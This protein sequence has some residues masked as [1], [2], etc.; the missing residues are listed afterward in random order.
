MVDKFCLNPASHMC[1]S[2]VC[3]CVDLIV[4]GDDFAGEY[5]ST[6]AFSETKTVTIIMNRRDLRFM[7]SQ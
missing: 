7:I 5:K 1:D 6:Q 3:V 4:L 2:I